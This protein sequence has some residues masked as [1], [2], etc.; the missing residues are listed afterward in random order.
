MD[1]SCARPTCNK[2]VYVESNG[3]VHPYCGRTCAFIDLRNI[4]TNIGECN[5]PNC[6]KQ[7]YSDVIGNVYDYCSRTCARSCTRFC[8][9]AECGRKAYVDPTDPSKF[10]VYCSSKCF[11]LDGKNL[12]VTKLTLLNP[13]DLDYINAEKKFLNGLPNAKIQG[14]LRIQMPKTIVHAHLLMKKQSGLKTLKMYH[15]TRALCD[16]GSFL[17]NFAPQCSPGTTC[18]ACGITRE[19]NNPALSKHGGNMWF[20]ESSQISNGYCGGSTNANLAMFMVDVLATTANIVIVNQAAATF[21][22]FMVIY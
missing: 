14:I 21:F 1:P 9:R 20:A 5:N 10:H 4:S 22:V 19:G 13:N 3:V 2:K 17:T 12:T 15:G 18:G 16:P 7:K 8:I 6:S 11:W